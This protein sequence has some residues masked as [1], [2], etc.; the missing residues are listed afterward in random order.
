MKLFTVKML[1]TF[2]RTQRGLMKKWLASQYSRYRL[3]A[4]IPSDR[5]FSRRGLHFSTTLDFGKF[6]KRAL[7]GDWSPCGMTKAWRA[8][9]WL[10]CRSEKIGA[11]TVS[12]SPAG[13]SRVRRVADPASSRRGI[14]SFYKSKRRRFRSG[15]PFSFNSPLRVAVWRIPG[16]VNNERETSVCS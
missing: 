11:A 16:Q 13:L 12:G 10:G 9:R 6:Y 2:G 5:F 7:S 14:S 1:A 3:A 15:C 8:R 4:T